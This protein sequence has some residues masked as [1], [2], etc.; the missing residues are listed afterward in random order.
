VPHGLVLLAAGVITFSSLF[1]ILAD[2][3]WEK[4]KCR[5]LDAKVRSGGFGTQSERAEYEWYAWIRYLAVI[6]VTCLNTTWL[7]NSE[8]Q[9]TEPLVSPSRMFWAF[10]VVIFVSIVLLAT[11]CYWDRRR[12]RRLS[13]IHAS[14]FWSYF[15]LRYPFLV[16]M[17]ITATRRGLQP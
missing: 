10:S 7:M 2:Y 8:P 1:F 3:G 14:L 17:T 11:D 15:W 12:Q 13:R 6:L 4:R 9:N 16:W 5:G